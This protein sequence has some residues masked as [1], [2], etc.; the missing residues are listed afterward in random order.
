[1][2]QLLEN[3]PVPE[4]MKYRLGPYSRFYEMPGED[5]VGNWFMAKNQAITEEIRKSA[6]ACIAA[7]VE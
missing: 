3:L 7:A 2:I 6:R 4:A 5:P 1:M